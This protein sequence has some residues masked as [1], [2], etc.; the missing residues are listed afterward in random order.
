MGAF[1]LSSEGGIQMNRLGLV[2]LAVALPTLAFADLPPRNVEER[3]PA[4]IPTRDNLILESPVDPERYIVGP[5]DHLQIDLWGL[6]EQ[7]SEVVVSGEGQVFI[8]RAGAFPAQGRSLS[9]LRRSIYDGLHHRYPRLKVLVSLL[10][11]RT[12]MV[13]VVGAV[14]QPGPYPATPLTHA[15]ALISRAS[16][17]P[18]GSTRRIE[19]RRHNGGPKVTVDL[20]RITLLGETDAD[21]K[22]L[23]GDIIYV[24]LRELEVEVSGAVKRPGKYELV[25]LKNVQELLTLAGGLEPNVS[26]ELPY[27]ITTRTPDDRQDVR[28]VPQAKALL[29]VL[30]PGDTV[31]VPAITDRQRTVVVEG[32]I[33][34][35]NAAEEADRSSAIEERVPGAQR[36]V[37]YKVEFVDGDGVRDL[38]IK[39]G[40]LQP[41][42]DGAGAYILRPGEGGVRQRI[43][44]D[45]VAIS[46]GRAAEVPIRAGDTLVIPARRES[47][48]VGGAVQRPGLYPFSPNL[49]P[50]DYLT[51]AGGA[52]RDGR[53]RAAQ[54]VRRGGGSRQLKDV[55][56]IEP[57]DI[58]TVP[59]KRINSSEW[60]G[61]TFG[62]INLAVV[63]T[64]LVLTT[65]R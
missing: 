36:E 7:S 26:S 62:L 57:G 17:Q 23:D 59:E 50:L 14:A 3:P 44:V 24:P 40:G 8:P 10:Q 16:P 2:C 53:P 51:F 37:S 32:A 25:D 45:V 20:A 61:I 54:V 4:A 56:T 34:R 19:L 31:H 64:T 63:T 1:F 42:A 38:V 11:P 65:I 39:A 21:S 27:R 28:A 58:I 43:Q 30:H 49:Q 22:L 55:Q 13:Y 48:I 33:R 29:T 52:T 41:W 6:Q 35:G 60:I 18:K 5:G 46:L 9:A 47:I 12:F 15:S